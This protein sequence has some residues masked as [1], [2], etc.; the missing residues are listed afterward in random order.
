MCRSIK[1]LRAE[2]PASEEEIRAAALQFVRKVS[3]YRE[4]S[5]RNAEAF[6]QAVDEIEAAS[7]RLLE[8]LPP[9]KVAS[10]R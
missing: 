1:R 7:A 2:E 5:S 6:E 10:P 9:L 8:A 3:G 4:P